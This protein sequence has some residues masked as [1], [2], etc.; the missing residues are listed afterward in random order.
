MYFRKNSSGNDVVEKVEK[1][2]TEKSVKSKRGFSLFKAK[3]NNDKARRL[4]KKKILSY[5]KTF[6]NIDASDTPKDLQDK[7][8]NKSGDNLKDLTA[9]YEAA[10]Y[11]NDVIS[12]SELAIAKKLAK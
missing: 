2:I 8:H 11:G 6:I 9:I 12:N 3:N 4:Y 5:N 7:I 1:I 10:R